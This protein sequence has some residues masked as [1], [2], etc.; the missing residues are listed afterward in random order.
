MKFIKQALLHLLLI[1]ILFFLGTIAYHRIKTDREIEQLR[2]AGYYHPVSVGDRWLNTA[3]FGN[4]NGRYTIV[5]LAGLGMGDFPVA[6]RQMTRSLEADH[7]VVF[8]DRAGY[9]LSDDTDQEMTIGTI[10]EDYRQALQYAGMKKPYILLAHSIGGAYANHWVSNYPDEIKAVVL[11]DGTQLSEEAFA[12]EPASEVDFGDR[13]LAGLAKLGF[14]RFFLRD[15]FYQYPDN[16]TQQEQ[17]LGDALM[18]MT[19]D[20]IAPV[21]EEGM[22]AGNAQTAFNEMVTN[23]VPKLYICSSWGFQTQNEILETNEWINRQIQINGLDMELRDVI[24]TDE[25]RMKELLDQ[26]KTA[27]EEII[28]PYAQ[29]MGNCEVICLPGDHMIY[30]QKPEA[31]G[32]LIKDFIDGLGR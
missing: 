23:D 11:V 26:Y 24:N 12:D 28:Y 19:L 21:S 2:E 3:V 22:L 13:I 29:K 32:Q 14:S 25:A 17:K 27:R 16:Y 30:E 20:S 9:G 18:L 4:E 6:A 7:R 8:V 15:Y 1:C 31:C 5:G 10:V